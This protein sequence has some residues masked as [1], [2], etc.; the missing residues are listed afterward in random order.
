[1]E[2]ASGFKEETNSEVQKKPHIFSLDQPGLP[3]LV[4]KQL[5]MT[6]CQYGNNQKFLT[7]TNWLK[8]LL[9]VSMKSKTIC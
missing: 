4:A 8:L 3:K 1:M 7:F 2:R 9:W 6:C 5:Q